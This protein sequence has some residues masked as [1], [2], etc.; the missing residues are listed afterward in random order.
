MSFHAQPNAAPTDTHPFTREMKMIHRI[1]RRESALM[2]KLVAAVA[3]GD[4]RRAAVLAEAWRSYQLGLHLHHSHED[5]LLWP[6]LLTRMEPDAARVQRMEE[7]HQALG[8][9]L[10]RVEVLLVDWLSTA[11]VA[12]RGEVVQALVEHHRT[13][14]AHLDEEESVV[15]PLVERHIGAAEWRE[16]GA[17]GLAA[18]PRS[19]RLLALGAI[20][21]DA[22]EEERQDFLG[23]LPGPARLVWWLVGQHR[24][25]SHVRHIR[26]RDDRGL[27][28]V[29][30]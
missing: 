18:T 16:V 6:K 7:Q 3:E 24:Y 11:S 21:E 1:F 9:G 17:R 4:V 14:C 23:R 30:W 8:L 28:P 26:G 20:L 12:R 10:E 27:R 22:S 2:P 15:M 13:L 25:R 29:G 5:E 19:K